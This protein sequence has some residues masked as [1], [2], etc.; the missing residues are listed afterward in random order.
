M[1]KRY[2]PDIWEQIRNE[3]RAG[4]LSVRDISKTLQPDGPTEAAIRSKAKKEGWER[5]LTDQVRA[6]T[7]AKLN[8][9]EATASAKPQEIIAAAADRNFKA[10]QAHMKSLGKLAEIEEKLLERIGECFAD[11]DRVAEAEDIAVR[12]EMAMT[13]ENPKYRMAAIA[14]LFAPEELR[15]GL[16]KTL[17]RC[18]G[19]LTSAGAKRIQLERQALNIDKPEDNPSG[20]SGWI[21]EAHLGCEPASEGGAC[22]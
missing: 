2:P 9:A 1:A 13:E 17:T 8:A 6:A 21:F 4:T 14:S 5:D 15:S 16:L 12:L 20:A 18:Y 10:V 22:G 7:R 19:D 11:F 3:Y